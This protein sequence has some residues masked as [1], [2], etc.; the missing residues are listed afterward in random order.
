MGLWGKTSNNRLVLQKYD[1]RS[2][3]WS[4]VEDVGTNGASRVC[5]VTAN[6]TGIKHRVWNMTTNTLFCECG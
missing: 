3:S 1:S 2:G 5:R 6:K 4:Y